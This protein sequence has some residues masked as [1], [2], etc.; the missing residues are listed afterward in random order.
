MTMKNPMLPTLRDGTQF[1]CFASDPSPAGPLTEIA[2][3]LA[4]GVLRFQRR[5]RAQENQEFCPD[6]LDVLP[7]PRLTDARG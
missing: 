4:A 6:P 2:A 5:R 1:P 7:D 3:I